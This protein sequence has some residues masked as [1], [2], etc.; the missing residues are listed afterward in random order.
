MIKLVS[1]SASSALSA[2]NEITIRRATAEDAQAIAELRVDVW[3][4]TYRG[5]MPDDYLD[6]M[7]VD[8]SEEL[9]QRVLSADFASRAAVLVA[10][11]GG[12]I[13]GFAAGFLMAEERH[14][15]DAELNAVYLRK[16]A[17]RAG[18]GRC[19]VN[20]VANACRGLG[21]HAML[22]WVMQENKGACRFFESLGAELVV[23]Q[24]FVWDEV[25]MI[26][27]GYIW[28]ELTALH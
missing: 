12:E 14:G 15:A 22:A 24:S 16:D 13:V 8:Q 18:W 4:E 23:E 26:E 9:W 1:S 6:D 20:Q 10:V 5:I 21:A 11:R 27:V 17:R 3:L 25:E 7:S 28:S 2:T 19:L